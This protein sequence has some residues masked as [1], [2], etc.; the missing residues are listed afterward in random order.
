MVHGDEVFPIGAEGEDF[1]EP[2]FRLRAGVGE[3]QG[4][5][6]GFDAADDLRCERCADVAG[7][8]EVA[9][10]PGDE[11]FYLDGFFDVGGDDFWSAGCRVIG[12]RWKSWADGCGGFLEVAQGGG[13]CPG[14][15]LREPG[16]EAGKA[17]FSLDAAFGAE[18]FV[19]FID[20]DAAEAGEFFAGV[21]VGEHQGKGLRCGDEG[22]GERFPQAGAEGGWGIAGA[23]FGGEGGVV[24]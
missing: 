19:P 12:E 21:C 16:A 3:K 11:G 23:G 17:E 8:G 4:G 13:E 10:F 22:V 6:G 1:L 15:Y 24:K 18:E 2:D 9:D 7:P 20:D 5:G 14:A